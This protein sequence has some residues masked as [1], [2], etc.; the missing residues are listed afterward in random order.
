MLVTAF[1]RILR[2]GFVSFY[3]N[4]V[5]SVAAILVVTITLFVIGSLIMSRAVLEYSLNQLKD[6]V[7]VNVYFNLSAPE[8]KI[9]ALKESLESLPEV[10]SVVYVSKSEALERF[11]KRH[12]SDYLTLQAIEELGSNPLGDALNIK[13]KETSQYESIAKF[14]GGES[15]IVKDNKSIIDKVNYYQNKSVI[16]KLNNIIV[17]GQKLGVAVTLVLIIISIIITFNTIRLIIFI[18]RDEI[19][20]MRLVGASNIYIRGP[21]MV[22]GILYGLVSSIIAM[23]IFYPVTLWLGR[24]ATNF[25]GGLNL[26]QYYTENFFQIFLI[27]L[28]SGSILGVI[29]AYLAVH[30]YLST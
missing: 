20:V 18:S 12:E 23:G 25:L 5:V 16:D 27:M 11:K 22:G 19:S 21:F 28:V 24:N 3:R 9:I 10:S 15:A 17:S 6:K 2:S 13:A 8:D 1:K 14:L 30:K 7:D 26:F 4:S 29:S